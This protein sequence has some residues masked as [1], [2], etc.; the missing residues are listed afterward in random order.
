VFAVVVALGGKNLPVLVGEAYAWQSD[1]QDSGVAAAY[2]VVILAVSL[3]ATWLYLRLLRV[4]Q[5]TLA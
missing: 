3:A 1:Y 2:A 4:R 5:E